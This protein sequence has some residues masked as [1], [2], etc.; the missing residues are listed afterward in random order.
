MTGPWTAL[1]TKVSVDY[2][3]TVSA[4]AGAAL[5][6]IHPETGLATIG[7]AHETVHLVGERHIAGRKFSHR[8]FLLVRLRRVAGLEACG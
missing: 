5:A 8:G 4:L 7:A 3:E 2:M 6:G 1:S